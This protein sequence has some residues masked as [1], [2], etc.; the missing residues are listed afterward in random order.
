MHAFSSASQSKLTTQCTNWHYILGE[1]QTHSHRQ[2]CF[3]FSCFSINAAI[4]MNKTYKRARAPALVWVCGSVH[5]NLPRTYFGLA[6]PNLWEKRIMIFISLDSG[7]LHFASA[8]CEPGFSEPHSG[9]LW[10]ST[11]AAQFRYSIILHSIHLLTNSILNGS[12]IGQSKNP[13]RK[14]LIVMDFVH[15]VQR[16]EHTFGLYV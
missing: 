12:N 2:K 5:K 6:S 14:G 7:I 9:K 1:M 4:V 16:A 15:V 10:S 13:H 8:A 11:M 3:L